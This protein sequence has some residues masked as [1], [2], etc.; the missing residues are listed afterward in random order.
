MKTIKATAGK[1]AKNFVILFLGC[2]LIFSSCKKDPGPAGPTGQTGPQGP[3]A[4]V[5]FYTALFTSTQTFNSFSFPKVID[6]TSIVL[7]YTVKNYNPSDWTP[8]PYKGP[9]FFSGTNYTPVDFSF[10]HSNFGAYIFN[11]DATTQPNNFSFKIAV[12]PAS[13]FRTHRNVNYKSY[14]EVKTAFNLKD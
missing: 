1:T 9:I 13:E 4:K 12:I 14:Q 2:G 6:S 5:Y 3:G 7:C 8:L 11:S 10:S